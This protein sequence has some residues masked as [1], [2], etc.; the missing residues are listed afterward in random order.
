MPATKEAYDQL[1][2]R[3]NDLQLKFKGGLSHQIATGTPAVIAP[4]CVRTM[5]DKNLGK[6]YSVAWSSDDEMICAAHQEG[7][8]TIKSSANGGHKRLPIIF[9][10]REEKVVPLATVFLPGDGAIAVGGMDN[11]ITIFDCSEPRCEKKRVLSKHEGYV[12]SLKLLGDKILSSSGDSTVK[13]WDTSTGQEVTSFCEH[14]S[15]CCQVDTLQGNPNL[16]VSCSTDTTCRV[17]DARTAKSTRW[18]KAKYSVNCCALFPT[19]TM[20]ACGCDS[21]SFEYWDIG[22]YNQ[23]GRGKASAFSRRARLP[24]F[25]AEHY[26]NVTISRKAQFHTASCGVA[27]CMM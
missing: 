2:S 7:A 26:L 25:H 22:S 15:D 19:G 5:A 8:V 12:S 3:F 21:A 10:T 16:F 9:P 20:V 4:K 27:T 13:L 1:L 18:F 24:C 11:V 14:E 6:V 17:W 23:I